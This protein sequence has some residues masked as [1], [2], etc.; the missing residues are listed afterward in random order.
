MSIKDLFHITIGSYPTDKYYFKNE[1]NLIKVSLLYADKTKL[2]SLASS[3]II[4]LFGFTS[5]HEDQKI[6]LM[7][8]LLPDLSF[9]QEDLFALKIGFKK[10]RELR[11][12]RIRN[13]EELLLFIQIK[14]V[15]IKAWGKFKDT[16]EQIAKN[17]GVN[18]LLPALESG[19]L[20]IK[21]YGKGQEIDYNTT[22]FINEFVGSLEEALISRKTYP[23][24]D[25]QTGKLVNAGIK[26]GLFKFPDSSSNK[27]KHV[28]FVSN[29]IQRLPTFDKAKVDEIL[30]I[31]KD[32]EKP[33]IRFRSAIFKLSEEI[34]HQQWDENFYYD[35]EKL[36]YREIIPTV[37]EI[38]EECKSNKYLSKL[39]SQATDNSI[40][41]P[42][43]N[44]V[45]GMMI[46]KLSDFTNIST[47]FLGLAA[48]TG[49]I[50]TKA[51]KEWKEKT[52]E[53]ERNQI[54]FY[55]KAGEMLKN[56]E[57]EEGK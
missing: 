30:D 45:L 7:E 28:G 42:A 40:G 35:S 22:D 11:R 3:Y 21:I 13:K 57:G 26:E 36:F 23:L 44:S 55:Y 9:S 2:C 20:E 1:L 32:L 48:G 47:I 56:I 6:N 16:I 50:A 10:Y 54:Y 14:N 18:E 38:E 31:R 19:L 4:S 17:S 8:K 53:I 34:A 39:L 29:I 24:F 49:T 52:K 51:L 5:L 41:L 43:T 46:A 37:E 27:T 15:F 12:K 33:L 25:D